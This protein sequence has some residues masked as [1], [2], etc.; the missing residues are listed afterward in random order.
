MVRYYGAALENPKNAG[1]LKNQPLP[2]N[3]VIGSQALA[4]SEFETDAEGVLR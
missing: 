4:G 1:L 2:G 3:A